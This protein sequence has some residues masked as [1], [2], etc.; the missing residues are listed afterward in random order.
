MSHA[1]LPTASPVQ[2]MRAEAMLT[3]MAGPGSL[4]GM[5]TGGSF[6]SSHWSEHEVATIVADYFTMLHDELLGK[7]YSKTEHRNGLLPRLNDRSAQSVE[8]KHGNISAVLIHMRLPYIDGY[9]PRSHSQSLLA[10][11][12]E[13]FLAAHEDLLGEMLNGPVVSPR[14][15][16]EAPHGSI[17]SIVEPPPERTRS[18]T[19][20]GSVWSG[21]TRKFDFLQHDAENRALGRLGE[22]FVLAFERHRLAELGRK[23]LAKKVEWV[24]TSRGDGT[25]FDILSFD[26]DA[27]ERYVEVKTTGL[28]KFFPFYVTAN[29]VKCSELSPQQ[30]SLY[31]VFDFS[32][33]PRLFILPGAL[34][35]TCRLQATEYRA[36]V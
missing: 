7:Q 5:P 34:S 12:V 20:E 9:K 4:V 2:D 35:Q 8:Y 16:P 21:Q 10:R 3:A 14:K 19:D 25:G 6:K 28:G 30:Y 24:S 1:S 22:E 27:A 26:R 13:A 36:V 15:A 29:E 11:Q 33:K 23:D 31:R 32:R 17:A 18:M